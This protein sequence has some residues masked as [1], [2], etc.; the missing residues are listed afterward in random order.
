MPSP[1][2][3]FFRFW[4]NWTPYCRH[5]VVLFEQL[6]ICPTGVLNKKRCITMCVTWP[7]S[8]KTSKGSYFHQCDFLDALAS[9][10]SV[11]SFLPSFTP[12]GFFRE[13]LD[14]SVNKTFRHTDLQTFQ[15]YN[16]TTLQ[17]YNL[18]TLQPY[19]LTTSQL[20]NLATLQPCNLTTLQPYNL[21]A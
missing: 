5:P 15:P 18:T 4:A 8:E 14:Q 11:L 17:P 13:I 19:N 12:S 20:Y 21:T 1:S 9:L 7:L 2:Y 3:H 16:F 10:E 6:M